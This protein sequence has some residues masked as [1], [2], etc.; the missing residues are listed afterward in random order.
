[1]ESTSVTS[2]IAE[3]PQPA[4]SGI[5][6]RSVPLFSGPPTALPPEIPPPPALWKEG[7]TFS[8]V[9]EKYSGWKGSWLTPRK[10]ELLTYAMLYHD[11]TASDTHVSSDKEADVSTRIGIGGATEILQESGRAMGEKSGVTKKKWG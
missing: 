2:G 10:R 7:D 6:R 8:S 3:I 5:P 4:S 11:D 1:M 9:L